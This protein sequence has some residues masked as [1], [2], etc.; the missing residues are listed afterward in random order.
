MLASN[1]F[2]DKHRHRRDDSR[3]VELVMVD[4]RILVEDGEVKTVDK[5]AVIDAAARAADAA[6]M[7]FERKY[8]GPI[9]RIQ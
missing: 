3:D 1:C 9:A 8:G 2:R 5:A 4:G 6:W 7:R